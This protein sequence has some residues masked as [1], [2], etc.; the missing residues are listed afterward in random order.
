MS[1]E[2]IG[3]NNNKI[4][5]HW[6]VDTNTYLKQTN[7]PHLKKAEFKAFGNDGFTFF[8][9]L[10]IINPL[11]HIPILSNIYRSITGDTID[12]GAKIAGGAIYG[13]PIGAIISS[14]NVA[15][16]HSSGHDLVEH[17]SLLLNNQT[18]GNIDTEVNGTKENIVSTNETSF[19]QTPKSNSQ[20][21]IENTNHETRP[22]PIVNYPEQNQIQSSDS[23]D[24]RNYNGKEVTEGYSN[25]Q[26]V[27]QPKKHLNS[28]IFVQNFV[29]SK[30]SNARV[31][32]VNK[33]E[34]SWVIEAMFRG[35]NKYKSASLL[36]EKRF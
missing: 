32:D 33:K 6:N 21:L 15:L 8:D 10:D 26:S 2:I 3:I 14:I 5:D 9:L 13:G 35:L 19:S 23:V 36:V 12:P 1:Q 18:R 28:S 34:P 27:S 31:V 17:T 20:I 4:Q 24:K 11:Q 25:T 29:N 7:A 30:R 16:E 22:I